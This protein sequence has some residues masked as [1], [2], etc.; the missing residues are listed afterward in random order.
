MI[1]KFF[2]PLKFLVFPLGGFKCLVSETK[3]ACN[4]NIATCTVRPLVEQAYRL[5]RGL[6]CTP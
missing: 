6:L 2:S 3:Q 1:T 5:I 4:A